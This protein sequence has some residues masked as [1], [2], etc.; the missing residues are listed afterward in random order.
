[1]IDSIIVIR[2]IPCASHVF[3]GGFMLA[4]YAPNAL[5]IFL[6]VLVSY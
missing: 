2:V 5:S 6:I 4:V 1:M 3:I